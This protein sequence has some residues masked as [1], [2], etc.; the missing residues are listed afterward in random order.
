MKF[1]ELE[2]GMTLWKFTYRKVY[3]YFIHSK[4]KSAVRYSK[5]YLGNPHYNTKSHNIGGVYSPKG[6][7][8]QESKGRSL[9]YPQYRVII[10]RAIFEEA[11]GISYLWDIFAREI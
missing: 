1:N 2:P 10:F 6:N 5:W 8:N 7:W 9:F 11:K 4:T 3:F